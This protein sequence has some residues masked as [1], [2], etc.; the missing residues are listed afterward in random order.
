[1]SVQRLQVDQAA[2]LVVDVQERLCA[3]ME[4]DALDR[5]LARTAAAVEGAR[6]LGLPV[7]VTEQYPKGL[8]PTHS[9]LKLRLGAFTPVEKLD[10]SAAVP[11]VLGALGARKQVLI[12]GMETHVCVFQ[13]A[14]A[15]ADAGY[16]PHLLVDAVLSR[17]A[18][19]RQVGLELCR[20]AGARLSTVEAAL[21]DLLGRAGSPEFKRVSAAVK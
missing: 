19:D 16:A 2:L 13:T 4:R 12:A 1:M 5:L 10:F 15:L 8:G 11:D 17:T 9:L 18:E 6:A 14:R 3:A 7:L 20:E 21:F